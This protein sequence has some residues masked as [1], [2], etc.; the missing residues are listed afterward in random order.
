MNAPIGESGYDPLNPPGG[1][2]MASTTTQR[3]TPGQF[4]RAAIDDTA[5]YRQRPRGDGDADQLLRKNTQMKVISTAGS[6][7]RVE[8]DSGEVGF[9]PSV[10]VEDPDFAPIQYGEDALVDPAVTDNPGLTPP[11]DPNAAELPPEGTIPTVIDPDP[12]AVEPPVPD[13]PPSPP[14]EAAPSV[15]PSPPVE[16]ELEEP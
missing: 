13:T 7:V 15:E 12:T 4:V 1:M 11:V 2:N 6:F 9:V 16:P 3:F 5:F 14:T 10:M 8:L